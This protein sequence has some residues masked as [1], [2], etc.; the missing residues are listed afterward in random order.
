MRAVIVGLGN[1]GRRYARFLQEYGFENVLVDSD[2]RFSHR[3]VAEVD[4]PRGVDVWIVST[5]T[6]DH[7]AVVQEILE[8]APMAAVL[9]EKPACHPEQI[10]TLAWLASRYREARLLVNDVYAHS[11]TVATLASITH[12]R[13]TH[14]PVAQITVEFSKNR[15]QDV[16]DGR[17][18]DSV[19]GDVGYEWF[20]MLSILRALLPVSTFKRY[21]SLPPTL[22][23]AEVRAEVALSGD[24]KIVLYSSVVGRIGFPEI[25]LGHFSGLSPERDLKDG[26][27]PRGSDFRY[28]VAMVT[29]RSGGTATAVFEPHY[30]LSVDYKNQ[31]LVEVSADGGTERHDIGENHLRSALFRQIDDLS[32]KAPRVGRRLRLDEHRHMA[33]LA[34]LLRLKNDARSLIT[35]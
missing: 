1:I 9:L 23:T 10:S 2:G 35:A 22:A 29:F 14:D 34:D 7:L 25:G 16:A 31:H 11:A 12:A 18:V 33:G 32:R 13:A 19:Y 21:L 17:F 15:L 6:A 24:L 5:P 30:G 3:R 28:R 26:N 20:H 27:I 8:L 4:D